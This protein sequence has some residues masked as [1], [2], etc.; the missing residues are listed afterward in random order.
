MASTKGLAC[1]FYPLVCLSI[2]LA[3]SNDQQLAN[4]PRTLLHNGQGADGSP[5]A[6]FHDKGEG[7][8]NNNWLIFLEGGG[9]CYTAQDCL[10]RSKTYR[11]SST[12]TNASMDFG[13]ILTKSN[14]NPDFCS[15]N[16]VYVHYCDGS[17]FTGDVESVSNNVT[18]RGARIFH[19]IVEDLLSKG[20]K[21]AQNCFFPQYILKNIATPMFIVMSAFDRVQIISDLSFEHL[22]CL[23]YNN[24][25]L[26]EMT[27]IQELR[28]E[29][30]DVLPTT[31]SPSFRGIWLTSC[32]T[33][34]VT[35]FSWVAPKMMRIVDNKTYPQ[36]FADWFY[37]RNDILDTTEEYEVNLRN[38]GNHEDEANIINEIIHKD[39][40]NLM[41]EANLRNEDEVDLAN[42]N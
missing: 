3:C 6:Y 13:F 5:P 17:S 31:S 2:A 1:L 14:W 19:A 12:Q 32:I 21:N 34:D 38:E 29:L 18:Y 39:E 33:H 23:M 10:D 16:R 30:L 42:Q 11:G 26:V 41:N 28:Q 20:M 25:S 24:C 22:A 27:A 40:T 15:W 36:V 7:E 8:G 4:V 35:R 37:D 9:W